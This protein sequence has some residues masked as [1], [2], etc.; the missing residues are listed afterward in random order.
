[1][2]IDRVTIKL[3]AG[4]GGNGLVSWIRAKY[5]PKGGPGGGNGSKGGDV[6]IRASAQHL[7]LDKYR[8]LSILRAE[9]G[10]G[11]GSNLQQGKQ[12][13]NLVIEVPCGTLIRDRSSQQL[14]ADLSDD[15]QEYMICRGGLGGRGNASYRTPTNQ[16]PNYATP[17]KFGEEMLVEMELKLIADVGLVGF[18]NAGKS[19]FIS[20]ITAANAKIAPYPFTTLFPNLG[21]IYYQNYR[22]ILV[23]DIPGIIEGAS[24]NRGLGLE[25]LRHIERAKVLAFVIDGAGSEGRDP[26]EDFATLQNEL[27]Q[28]NPELLDKPM[29]VLFNKC[30]LVDA[31]AN[32]ARFIESYPHLQ[33]K[34]FPLSAQNEEGFVPIA[35]ELYR[36]VFV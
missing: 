19:T 9:D 20:A 17:G 30:D 1:M 13:K 32:L 4:K 29:I 12:G 15:G 10:G 11:G 25:F 6:I 23:A 18:P 16:A 8:N 5:I 35:K 2:F 26:L 33:K 24:S 14:L 36:V 34:T 22:K 31:R 28:H 27:Q 21:C 3:I 7:S